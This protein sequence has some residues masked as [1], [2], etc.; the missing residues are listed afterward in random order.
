[1]SHVT[2][3]AGVVITDIGAV[4]AAVAELNSQGVSVEIAENQKPR[5]HG[6]DSVEKCDFVLK[7]KGAYDVGLKKN[8][9]GNYEPVLDVYQGHVGKYL[10]PTCPVPG[11]RAY[12]SQE[13]TQHEIGR[14]LQLY[15]KHAA[16]NAA[17]NAGHTVETC[18]IDDTGNI[19]LVLAVASY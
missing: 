1:M 15:A 16:M 18:T 7:L 5:V 3:L 4:R 10:A 19:N 2:K 17:A 8:K 13:H 14:F 12:Q 11:T 9:E 6:Y